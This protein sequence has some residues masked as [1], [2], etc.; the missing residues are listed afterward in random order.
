M[1]LPD[2]PGRPP[3]LVDG[4]DSMRRA[5]RST[6]RAGADWI[7]LSTTGGIASPHDDCDVA[8]LTVDEV[9]VAAS[10][11]A[12]R[13][14]GVMVHAF[15]GE[16]VDIAIAARVRSIE[17]APSLTEAQA[18]RMAAQGIWLVPTLWG[19]HDAIRLA[20]TGEYPPHA[21]EKALRFKGTVG[22]CVPI[23]REY[24]VNL[25]IGADLLSREQHGSNLQELKFMHEAGLTAEETLLA[26]TIGGA[27]LCG[28]DHVLGRIAPGFRFDAIVL[29]RDPSEIATTFSR[30]DSVTGV[31]KGGRPVVRHPLVRTHAASEAGTTRPGTAHSKS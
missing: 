11:A 18:E 27:R 7:K 15:G 30:P 23:A 1:R 8:E 9:S 16:G 13:S 4:A 19:L 29:D 6:F 28:V 10:E 21:S 14:K 24:G 31:F 5:V 25:A 17:H 20:E 26:A 12:R 2:Y 22:N 3:H